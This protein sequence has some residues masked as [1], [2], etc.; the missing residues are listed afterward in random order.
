MVL[1]LVARHSWD[2][3]QL[4]VKSTF[5]NSTLV[6]KVFM[7]QPPGFAK[8]GK[9]D[10]VC[11]LKKAL[12]GLTP[13]P[14]AWYS[15]IHDY[16]VHH[17]FVRSPSDSNLYVKVNDS[18]YTIVALYVDD[19]IVIGNNEQEI[20]SL[21]EDIKKTFKMTNMGLLHYFLRVE[22]Q[23]KP[24]SVFISQG[25]YAR[26]ILMQFQMED[27]KPSPTL[28]DVGVKLSTFSDKNTIY[29]TL[30]RQLIGGTLYRQLVGSLIYLTTTRPNIAFAVGIVSKFMAEPKQNH[31]LAAKRI[32]R[33]PRGTLQYRLEFV[34]ND[35]FKLQGY[36]DSD[37][38][39][40]VDTRK[41]M[42]G[43]SFSLGSTAM[44]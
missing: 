17:S 12:H 18:Q 24:G 13:A 9:E 39:G 28:I 30:D 29:S 22:V 16:F 42:Y 21:K 19:M 33:Y 34:Q 36:T 23:Q 40:C 25:K 37:W 27:C 43:H 31:W 15:R 35:N 10:F 1:A 5:L 4:D 20:D 44:T 11:R 26:E 8:K 38:V 3:H 32:L 41:S 14:R 6:E 2:I 7:E